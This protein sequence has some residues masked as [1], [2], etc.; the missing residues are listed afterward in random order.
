MHLP[1]WFLL[2]FPWLWLFVGVL[3]GIYIERVRWNQAIRRAHE[4]RKP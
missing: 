1:L 4:S 3:V 2:A